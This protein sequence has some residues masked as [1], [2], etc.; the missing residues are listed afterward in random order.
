MVLLPVDMAPVA[1]TRYRKPPGT[2]AG[3]LGACRAR[4]TGHEIL[5]ARGHRREIKGLVWTVPR[6]SSF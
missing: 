1:L 4:L 3:D 2:A 6:F 5:P